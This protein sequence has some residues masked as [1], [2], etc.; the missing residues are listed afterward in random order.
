MLGQVTKVF[1]NI[2]MLLKSLSLEANTQDSTW[3]RQ[4]EFVLAAASH[5]YQDVG[6]MSPFSG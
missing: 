2:G 6:A 5:D 1:Y 4:S 3:R